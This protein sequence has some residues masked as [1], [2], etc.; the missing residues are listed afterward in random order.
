MSKSTVDVNV[1]E[2]RATIV[3]RKD[4]FSVTVEVPMEAIV[5]LVTPKQLKLAELDVEQTNN[6][7][8]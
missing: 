6:P 1:N 2:Q 7:A 4:N 5:K 3:W 8:D